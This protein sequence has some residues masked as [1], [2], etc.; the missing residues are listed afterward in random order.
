MDDQKDVQKAKDTLPAEVDFVVRD[1]VLKLST[2]EVE[3]ANPEKAIKEIEAL[4]G[5][6]AALAQIQEALSKAITKTEKIN[7]TV[8]LKKLIE[9]L[10]KNEIELSD[11][12]TIVGEMI[13][14]GEI[15]LDDVPA[16]IRY[17]LGAKW[18]LKFR[19]FPE[20]PFK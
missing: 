16:S 8:G 15:K 18:A 6:S 13:K 9:K 3:K 14:K 1:A 20:S 17:R 12:K 5:N 4:I 7:W 10:E 11:F 19:T 2:T